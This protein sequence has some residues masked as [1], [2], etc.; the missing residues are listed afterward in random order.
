MNTTRGALT[1][2]AVGLVD[3]EEA[4]V[5]QHILE[6]AGGGTTWNAGSKS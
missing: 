3:C 4:Q 5:R 6:V 2:D 1:V